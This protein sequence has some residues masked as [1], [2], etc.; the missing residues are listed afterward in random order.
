MP[1]FETKISLFG[2]FGLE[3]PNNIHPQ[4]CLIAKFCK[5]KKFLN[6]GTKMP[7]LG[8]FDQKYLNWVF[9]GWNLEN[10][11]QCPWICLV[12]KF[13]AKIKILKFETKMPDLE[14]FGLEFKNNIV[15]FEFSTLKFV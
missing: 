10:W 8:I 7:Y 9:L 2:Y 11:N 4:I 5:K 1:K 13:G 14:I 6:L 12:A 15:I 3:F